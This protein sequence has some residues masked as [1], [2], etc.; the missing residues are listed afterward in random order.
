MNKRNYYAMDDLSIA[1]DL[2]QRLEQLRLNQNI[3]QSKVIYE[4][5]I[6]K[7]AYENFLEGKVKLE[8]FI[9]I[10]RLLGKLENLDTLLPSAP[11]TP[12]DLLAFAGRKQ[13]AGEPNP[14]ATEVL[15]ADPDAPD[16]A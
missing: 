1:K 15:A 16:P 9:G 14:N 7:N 4:L 13:H 5:G 6:T 2:G 8:V 11:F 12:T 10:L 3:S